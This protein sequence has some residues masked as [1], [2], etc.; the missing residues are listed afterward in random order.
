M[1]APYRPPVP[2]PDPYPELKKLIARLERA[3]RWQ[4]LMTMLNFLMFGY[5]VGASM[6]E[7]INN[8]WPLLNR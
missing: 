4:G 5:L 7:A 1:N 3:I 6:A 8:L 2:P